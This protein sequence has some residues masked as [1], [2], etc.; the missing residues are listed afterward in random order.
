MRRSPRRPR[1]V[2]AW[3]PTALPHAATLAEMGTELLLCELHAHTTW[4]DGVLSIAE[5]V[6]L[7]G[8][9]GFDVLCVTDHTARLDDPL[10]RSVD[11][12]AW[13]GYL[14]ELKLEAARALA[15]YGLLVLPGLELTDNR[16]VPDDSA[17]ALALGLDQFVSVE[18]GIVSAIF[19]AR[20][21]GAAIVAAH[22][23]TSGDWT[24]RRPT[25][26]LWRARDRFQ[27]II[28][29]W[30]LANGRELFAWIADARLPIVATGDFHQ[31]RD[32][33]SW[34]TFVPCRKSERALVAHLRSRAAVYVMPFAP[35]LAAP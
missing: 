31:P 28:D 11:S 33:A 22:P 20:T 18:R 3:P 29:R 21:H 19:E 13:P 12:W 32:L 7:Y 16:D 2:A 30:D 26:R 17:H 4:S 1:I 9:T 24:L 14:R 10:R 27:N 15:E 25:S 34:K 23:Y 6:D 35:D 8:T 5:L